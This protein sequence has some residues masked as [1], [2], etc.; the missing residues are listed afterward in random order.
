MRSLRELQEGFRD[1][2]LA[3][4]GVAPLANVEA[5]RDAE[6]IAVYRRTVRANYRNALA[7]T[8]PVVRRLAG[9]SRFD[10]AVDAFVVAHPSRSGDLNVYGDAFGDFLAGNALAI[11]RPWLADVARLEW[12]IDEAARAADSAPVPDAVLAALASI[13]PDRLPGAR[14]LLAPSCRLVASPF[15]IL[16]LWQDSANDD[17]DPVP[18]DK[19]D[20]ILLRRETEGILLE[21]IDAGTHA[22][23]AAIAAGATLAD[24]IERAQAVDASFDLGPALHTFIGNGTIAA[25]D[26]DAS[27]TVR[28]A[29]SD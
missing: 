28:R 18:G 19:P 8:Y 17:R 26:A 2:V 11:V 13:A 23:L 29:R 16:R 7:A 25:V 27:P 1:A 14:L 9:A 20:R 22:W 6:R 21:R 24:A 12:A 5:A 3:L 4:D 10:A 15:P